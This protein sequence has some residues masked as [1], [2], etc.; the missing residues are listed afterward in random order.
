MRVCPPTL[1]PKYVLYDE[2]V[3]EVDQRTLVNIVGVS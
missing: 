1:D 3:E 2:E